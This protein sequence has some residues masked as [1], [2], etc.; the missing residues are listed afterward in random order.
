[1]S[2]DSR[3]NGPAGSNAGP[4]HHVPGGPR[5]DASSLRLRGRPRDAHGQPLYAVRAVRE[6]RGARGALSA[7][8][9]AC[10]APARARRR[11]TPTGAH[12]AADGFGPVDTGTGA[13]R[14]HGG[15][16]REP[17]RR[18]LPQA[19]VVACLAGG[20]SAFV[21][22]DKEIR[23]SVDGAPRIL[24]TFADDVAG[25]LAEQEIAVGAHDIV[26]P[27][28][29]TAL[30][31][32][33]EV[34]VRHGRPL[35]LTV[36]GASRR[37]W[38]TEPTVDGALRALGVRPEGAYVSVS[39]SRRIGRAGLAFDVRTQRTLRVAA[40]GRTRALRTNAAT[41][42]A[43]LREAGVRLHGRDRLSAAVASFPRDGQTVTVTRIEVGRQVR[44]ESIPHGVRRVV[45]ASLP[46]GTQ[47]VQRAGRDGERRVTYA[48][49]TV[50]GVAQRPRRVG[51]EVVLRPRDAW[52]RVGARD[53]GPGA[54][55]PGA[56][57][58][59]G[60]H[61]GGTGGGSGVHGLDWDALARCESGGRADA[62]D[63]SG[64]Y[65]GLYQFDAATWRSL[66]GRGLPQNASRAEQTRMAK[67]LYTRRGASPWPVCGGRL[68]G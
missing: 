54:A 30:A 16:R 13:V 68:K 35:R 43:A 46:L 48:T 53:R 23:L 42:G 58:G 61:G 33:D 26:A 49:R 63:P 12:G 22:D 64:T 25:L 38:T 1:M 36:D 24:H 67:L 34:A 62:V 9:A 8:R 51:E 37:V 19:L 50:D 45:D 7:A 56:G 44:A 57:L 55:A 2:T 10:G 20:T 14:R 47:V 40:D 27:S 29:H 4:S 41:V 18:L 52:V 59:G 11:G 17:L 5:D 60:G 65:G 21:A 66:G 32:G 3:H 28:P 31:G 15:R 39:R 6:V